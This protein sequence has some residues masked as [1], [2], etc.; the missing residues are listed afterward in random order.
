MRR[1]SI[2]LGAL[3]ACGR[4]GFGA[5]ARGDGGDSDGDGVGGGDDGSPG[6]VLNRAFVTRDVF[7][8]NLGGVAGADGRCAAAAAAQH[9]P[10]TFI[11][12][13]SSASV[14]AIDRFAGSRGWMRTDGVI[15]ADTLSAALTGAQMFAPIDRDE[16]GVKLAYGLAPK[17][18]TGTG[19]DGRLYTGLVETCNNW[20]GTGGDGWWGNFA[21]SGGEFSFANGGQVC[22][23]M[24]HLACFEIGRSIPVSPPSL[25]ISGRLAF[26]SGPRTT[27]GVPALDAMC[28][29]EATAAGLSGTYRAA[30][31]TTTTTI[32]SRFTLDSRSVQRR[33]GTLVAATASAFLSAT[34]L[35]SFVNQRADGS[36][37]ASKI[38]TGTGDPISVGSASDT[39]TS[40]TDLAGISGRYGVP[41][42]TAY[43][44]F[45]GD[46]FNNSYGGTSC[47]APL[48]VLC[49]A[50]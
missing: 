20:S 11:A 15:V 10:G 17:L 44:K 3:A 21:A 43:P 28:G 12:W 31:A 38:W 37:T 45:W 48:S 49:L 46:E 36:Y 9:L 47:S 30:V 35:I 2:L 41:G 5:N 34:D 13:I 18:W 29:A 19:Q 33:D 6:P 14:D 39:C 32:A 22:T 7:D 16:A 25:P 27:A 26:V 1:W 23:M 50:Q 8:G 40:W 24:A 42:A 4:L